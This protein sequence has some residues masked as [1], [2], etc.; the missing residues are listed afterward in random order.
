MAKGEKVYKLHKSWAK[1]LGGGWPLTQVEC[2][3]NKA[4]FHLTLI[5][6]IQFKQ[7]AGGRTTT[8]L[9]L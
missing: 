5:P 4:V 6:L 7:A 2:E 1:T 9:D 3:N 8:R